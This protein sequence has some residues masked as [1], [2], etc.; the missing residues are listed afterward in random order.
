MQV[1]ALKIVKDK[2]SPKLLETLVK[3]ID[4][5]SESFID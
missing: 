5:T 1:Q 4:F 3:Y 2:N